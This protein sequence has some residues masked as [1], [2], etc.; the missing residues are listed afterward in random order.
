M[1][2][3]ESKDPTTGPLELVQQI[4]STRLGLPSLSGGRQWAAQ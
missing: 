3:V 1:K 4:T 2:V